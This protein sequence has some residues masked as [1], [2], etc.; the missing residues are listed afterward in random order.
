MKQRLVEFRRE[1]IALVAE[2]DDPS[3]VVQLNLHLFP[4]TQSQTGETTP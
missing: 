2:S 3:R 4:L 1:L